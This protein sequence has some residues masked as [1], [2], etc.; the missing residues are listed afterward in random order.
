M[1]LLN[2]QG[3]TFEQIK[4]DMDFIGNAHFD[5]DNYKAKN[6]LPCFISENSTELNDI[7]SYVSLL[8]FTLQRIKTKSF[9]LAVC[10]HYD[11]EDMIPII[12]NT[13]EKAINYISLY[14]S[15]TDNSPKEFA[16]KLF[17]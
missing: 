16:E 10:E 4:N 11:R 6:N 8:D 2:T 3:K 5:I 7:E 17:G 1:K 13:N 14:L 15:V 12:E 9:V